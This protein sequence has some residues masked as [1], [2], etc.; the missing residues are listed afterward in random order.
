MTAQRRIRKNKH[1]RSMTDDDPYT[2]RYRAASDAAKEARA[3]IREG[4]RGADS[5]DRIEA[6]RGLAVEIGEG[7]RIKGVSLVE[8]GQGLGYIIEVGSDEAAPGGEGP[9]E[10]PRY[11]GFAQG[12]RLGEVGEPVAGEEAVRSEA[13]SDTATFFERGAAGATLVHVEPSAPEQ[14][15][16]AI[17]KF[18]AEAREEYGRQHQVFFEAEVNLIPTHVG[19]SLCYCQIAQNHWVE[20]GEI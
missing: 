6:G 9:Q 19:S 11:Q 5:E 18:Q 15:L 7:A 12:H 1:K 8:E 10:E 4:S 17:R 20:L 2:Q 16:E 14:T 3:R 13:S